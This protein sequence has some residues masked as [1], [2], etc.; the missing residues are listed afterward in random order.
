MNINN[1]KNELYQDFVQLVNNLSSGVIKETIVPIS[2]QM[3][4]TSQ[5]MRKASNDIGEIINIINQNGSNIESKV[6]ILDKK[7]HQEIE[8][9][10][11]ELNRNNQQLEEKIRKLQE[12]QDLFLYSIIGIITFFGLVIIYLLTFGAK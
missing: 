6:N 12:R 11:Y 4:T 3:E 7:I 1:P 5:I 10:N 2:N 8:E 9:T